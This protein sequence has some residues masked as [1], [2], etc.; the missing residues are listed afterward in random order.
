ML[1]HAVGSSALRVTLSPH[2][3]YESIRVTAKFIRLSCVCIVV[4]DR[5]LV[6]GLIRVL[7]KHCC[8]AVTI[9]CVLGA[10]CRRQG[11]R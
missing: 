7:F 5:I 2:S 10:L 4:R 1:N 9:C 8:S 3:G 6:I 11:G